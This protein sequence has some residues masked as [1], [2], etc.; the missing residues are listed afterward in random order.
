M[1]DTLEAIA[2]EFIEGLEKLGHLYEG[3]KGRGATV[4][5]ELVADA[6]D[7]IRKA[8]EPLVEAL[9]AWDEL[10]QE[11]ADKHPC[12]DLTLRIILR[13]RARKLTPTALAPYE[14]KSDD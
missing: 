1:P 9:R 12:P 7:A 13:K 2:R 8:A 10:D 6:E 4:L 14:D 5:P 3:E 11:A